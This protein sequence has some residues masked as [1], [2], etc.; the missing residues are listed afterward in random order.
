[1]LTVKTYLGKSGIEGIGVFASEDIYRG[2]LVWEFNELIDF[3]VS[4]DLVAKALPKVR[5][6]YEKY[7]W[8]EKGKWIMSVDNDH[9]VN[10]S[11]TPNTCV[12]KQSG[13]VYASKFI[14]KGT[15]I[16]MDYRTF[17]EI[18]YDYL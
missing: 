8:F 13:K 3:V 18:G 14:P 1:M 4:K 11:R 2:E 12:D 17:D 10:H 7:G 6:Y 9:F 16:T 15:E 5:E